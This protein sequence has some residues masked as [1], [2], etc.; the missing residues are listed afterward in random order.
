MSEYRPVDEAN[1]PF[2]PKDQGDSSPE[3]GRSHDLPSDP[4]HINYRGESLYIDTLDW[5]NSRLLKAQIICGLLLFTLFGL[6]DQ[7]VGT[8]IPVFQ[9]YYEISDVQ[10]GYLFLASVTGY[11]SMG[12]LNGPIHNW[13]GFRGI[14]FIGTA[15]MAI[16]YTVFSLHPPFWVIVS[17]AMLSGIG[18]GVLD[19]AFNSWSGQ[20]KDSNQILGLLHG[21]FGLGC[22]ISPT[23]I[24]YLIEREENPWKWYQ[25]YRLL[26]GI[27]FVGFV[28][29][30]ILFR[31]ETAGKYK[32]SFTLK[33]EKDTKGSDI[34]LE[35][36]GSRD[37][38][39]ASGTRD[40]GDLGNSGDLF[41][42]GELGDVEFS[43]MTTLKSKLVWTF[44]MVLFIYVGGEVAFGS[45]L[46]SYLI[47]ISKLE[48]TLASHV[49]TSFWMGLTIGRI[50]L[51]FVTAA[52]FSNELHANMTYIVGSVIG[53][54]SFYLISFTEIYFLYFVIALAAGITIGPIFQTSVVAAL[55]VLPPKY[56]NG[57]GFIC[58]C[59]GG[60]GSA[61]VPFLVGVIANSG[62]TGL[63]FFPLVII[64][65]Y[66]VLAGVWF[67]IMV[68]FLPGYRRM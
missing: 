17:F 28:L 34:E 25:F 5:R 68:R 65:L 1:E 9:D 64:F 12:L 58:S 39:G 66:C 43:M 23:L 2:I 8:L 32:Y 45:W 14:L 67:V 35:N 26:A 47:R 57:I 29:S 40:S 62:P 18:C 41:N 20:L 7:T 38:T 30:L 27:A 60:G 15:S 54:T 59:G 37:S 4:Y 6:Q 3:S 13:I 48:Y 50:G 36:T 33:M 55:N 11:I 21:C 61:T 53:Y 24:T 31:Y 49:A 42:S 22:M 51:G 16:A 44:T 46:I 19:A 52:Y 63:K 10:T 56:H